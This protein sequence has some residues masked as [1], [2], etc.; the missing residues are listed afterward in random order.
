[1]GIYR[2][3]TPIFI[4]YSIEKVS[5]IFQKFQNIYTMIDIIRSS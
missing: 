5:P 2:K 4:L 3:A 1:M